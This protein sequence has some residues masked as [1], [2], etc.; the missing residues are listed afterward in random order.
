MK[1]FGE[2]FLIFFSSRYILQVWNATNICL[3]PKND[4][5]EEASHFRP[6]SLCNVIYKVISKIIT[7]R[8]KPILKS[9]VSPFQNAFVPGRLL[10]DNCL[11]AHE[12]V[13]VIKQ[14]KKGNIHLAALRLICSKL[15]I[16]S[17]GTSFSGF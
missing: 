1:I 11:I 6:I 15:T 16:K 8:L 9:I 10:T 3:I 5:P 12:L 7:N 13:N 2:L 4:R 17:T 14:R